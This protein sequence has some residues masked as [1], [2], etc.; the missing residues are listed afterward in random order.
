MKN[1][2]VINKVSFENNI[3]FYA[4]PAYNKFDEQLKQSLIIVAKI[5]LNEEINSN[6]SGIVPRFIASK[7]EPSWKAENLLSA[8]YFSIFYMKPGS[9]IYRECA[10]PACHNHFLVKTS[11]S[12]KIY[13]CVNCRN[14][15]SQRNHRKKIKEITA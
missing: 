12:R 2:G 4:N 7:M 14:A 3:E 15:T 8:L 10:N 13:C 1:V 5:V 9:E 11:N 6:L